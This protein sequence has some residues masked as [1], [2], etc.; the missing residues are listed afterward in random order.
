[1]RYQDIVGE[2][3]E[4]DWGDDVDDEVQDDEVQDN[5]PKGKPLT[6][7]QQQQLAVHQQKKDREKFQAAEKKR[8]DREAQLYD[9][10]DSYGTKGSKHVPKSAVGYKPFKWP[11]IRFGKF[12]QRSRVGFDA[13]MRRE[14]GNV[15]HEAGVSCFRGMPYNNGILIREHEGRSSWTVGFDPTRLLYPWAKQMY[16]QFV[17]WKKDH[18]PMDVFLITG[19]LVSFGKNNEWLDVGADG[20][21]LI[22]TKKPYKTAHIGPDKLWLDDRLTL[23]QF[24]EK[25]NF[26]HSSDDD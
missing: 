11:M 9:P 13:E 14:M 5:A 17:R 21:Y 16:P 23:E 8:R 18:T 24:Y 20:E 26:S 3:L 12:N 25:G 15:T 10:D 19:H 6:P 7:Q 1:M 2:A 22:D 4:L